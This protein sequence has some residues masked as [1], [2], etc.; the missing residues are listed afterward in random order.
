MDMLHIHLIAQL[1][2]P[3]TDSFR[4]T[5]WICINRGCSAPL[6]NYS[7]CLRRRLRRVCAGDKRGG[8]KRVDGAGIYKQSRVYKTHVSITNSWRR[9]RWS[10]TYSLTYHHHILR[11][12]VK[13]GYDNGLV[14]LRCDCL[15]C[16]LRRNHCKC[17]SWTSVTEL[18]QTSTRRIQPEWCGQPE[19]AR[20]RHRG[21]RRAGG[22]CLL[23]AE[24]QMT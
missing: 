5:K 11:Y 14:A 17:S 10:W 16:R 1:Y 18:H 9:T 6:R 13:Q 3:V 4:T 21:Q 2:A 20:N 7:T 8:G 23:D 24:A 19:F 15:S 12:I 22:T